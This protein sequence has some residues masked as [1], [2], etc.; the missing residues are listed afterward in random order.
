MLG[1][2]TTYW[3]F[4][5]KLFLNKF[6]NFLSENIFFMFQTQVFKKIE[7]KYDTKS[8]YQSMGNKP[9]V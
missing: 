5:F 8:Q 4:L 9:S 3:L 7:K 1:Y 2:P 6:H